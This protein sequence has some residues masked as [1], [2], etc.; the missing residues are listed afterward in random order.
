[1]R[2]Q[3]E[4]PDLRLLY[5]YWDGK[6]DGRRMPARSDLDPLD[7][8]RLL[9]HILL[10]DVE[11]DPIRFF[12][13]V[14][15]TGI[16]DL[17]GIDLTGKY[18]YEGNGS[19]MSEQTRDWNIETALSGEPHYASGRYPDIRPGQVGRYYR[20]GLPLSGDGERVDKLLICFIREWEDRPDDDGL[21]P[22]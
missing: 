15:G 18:L 3:I 14:Y 5:D 16:V 4:H 6:R 13:R 10:V 17:R 8:P 2:D 21:P 12:V 22:L 11:H 19:Q 20:L 7:I 1:M 9:K